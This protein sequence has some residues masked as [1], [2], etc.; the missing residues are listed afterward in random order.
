[1]STQTVEIVQFRLKPGT[2][3]GAFLAAAADTQ[4]AI[5]RLPGFLTRELLRGGD[6]L[7][8]DVV[9]WRSE[10]EALAAAEAFPSMPEVVS[11]VA[12]IDET[13]MTMLHLAQARSFA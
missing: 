3:E 7:W 1:M 13:A 2:D 4:A 8:V 6:G 11:F 12:M 5:A 9:H 10:A